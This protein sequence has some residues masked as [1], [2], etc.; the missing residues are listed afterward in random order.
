MDRPRYRPT[1][2][3]LILLHTTASEVIDAMNHHEAFEEYNL[4]SCR[5]IR[6]GFLRIPEHSI[7][8]LCSYSRDFSSEKNP[9]DN[10]WRILIHPELL[11]DEMQLKLTLFHEMIHA[12]LGPNERHGSMFQ[13]LESFGHD[14]F[15]T[16]QAN[17][18]LCRKFQ[19]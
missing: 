16:V 4:E 9:C 8:G 2:S 14:L 10:V 12:L 13:Y 17:K 7:W 18:Y 15:E 5:Q 11:T 6:I 19:T 3:E 1:K